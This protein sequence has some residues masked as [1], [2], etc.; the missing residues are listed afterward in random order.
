MEDLSGPGETP[1]TTCVVI[2]GQSFIGRFLVLRLLR[3]RNW[4]VRIADSS[5]I[6]HTEQQYHLFDAVSSGRAAY[7]QVDARDKSQLIRAIDGSSV[8]FYVETADATVYDLYECYKFIVQG[9]KNVVNACWGCKVKQL[10]YSSSADV[11]F[12]GSCHIRNGDESMPYPWKYADMLTEMKAQA[13]ALVLSAND[14]HGLLTC[15]LRPSNV[16][17][18]KDTCLV[19]FVVNQANSIWA[20]FILG[21]GDTLSDFTYVENV[22]HA[23]VCAAEALVTRTVSVAGKAF[24]V[25][26]CEP[27]NYW[28]FISRLYEG[29]GYQRPR[30]SLP[31]KLLRFVLLLV[32]WTRS[33]L[34]SEPEVSDLLRCAQFVVESSLL[35]RTFNCTAAMEHIKYSPIVTMEEGIALTVKSF[36]H[37]AKGSS[38]SKDIHYIELSKAEAMLGYG[39]VADILLWRDEMETFS[40]FLATAGLF[41][42]F[43][44]SE[45]TF[46][47]STAG[48]LLVPTFFLIVISL[49]PV[50]ILQKMPLPRLEISDGTMRSLIKKAACVWN[51]GVHLVKSLAQGENWIL[52]SKVVIPLYVLKLIISHSFAMLVAAALVSAFTSFFIYEQYEEEVDEFSRLAFIVA[53]CAWTLLVTSLPAPI[54]SLFSTDDEL[55][56]KP[57][58]LPK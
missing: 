22:A 49:L 23:H 2:G 39:K 24:F 38:T 56:E 46:I 57:T 31:S 35:T 30:L 37:L 14:C 41:Y 55:D 20:K 43:F 25:T 53:K 19:H 51:E 58:R 17:G 5:P 6:L 11:V 36:S 18:P 26:N 48:L 28:K 44:V 54:A 9:A 12:D 29:L 1:M 8:V 13:E 16:F 34:G 33:K 3:L 10:I 50:N 7:F 27:M 40:S 21:S 15:A 32:K 4:I 45:R 42:W 52:F 47:S